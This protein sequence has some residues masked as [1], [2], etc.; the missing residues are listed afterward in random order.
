M[1]IRQIVDIV[2]ALIAKLNF[3]ITITSNIDN[4]GGKHQLFMENTYYM[5]VTKIIE[6]DGSEYR[7]TAVDFNKSINVESIGPAVT[8][9][10]TTF[11]LPAPLF[12][13]GTI[14]STDREIVATAEAQPSTYPIVYLLEEID[15]EFENR[16]SMLLERNSTITLFFLVRYDPENKS[17][18]P[19]LLQDRLKPISNLDGQFIEVLEKELGIGQLEGTRRRTNIARFAFTNRAGEEENI[20]SDYL[21][22][23]RLI[24]TLPIKKC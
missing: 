10:V 4:G 14:I 9:T 1:A 8:V 24:I 17:L 12:F 20:F 5:T 11:E 18:N 2:G 22:G 3:T 23:V 15:E 16:K 13:H 7:V 21:S 19:N 6:I